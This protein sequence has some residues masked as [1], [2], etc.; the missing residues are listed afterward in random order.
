MAVSLWRDVY[1]GRRRLVIALVIGFPLGLI[2]A[3]K[4]NTWLDT[5]SL[6]F[7]TIGV[8]VPNFVSGIVLIIIFAAGLGWFK[9]VENDYWGSIK[10]WILPAFVLALP[11]T[12]FLARL[13]RSSMLEVMRMDFVRTA[14]AKGLMS[15]PSSSG[16]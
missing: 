8:G 6:F 7:A 3:L 13:T 10:P 4:Q 14:R 5:I 11:T 2:A 1:P 15:A 12:A 16:I 9:V